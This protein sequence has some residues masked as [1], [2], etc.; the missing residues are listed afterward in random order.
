[1]AKTNK[2]NF[3]IISSDSTGQVK[4][5]IN[6]IRYIYSIGGHQVSRVLDLEKR[7]PGKA[8]D[9]LKKAAGKNVKKLEDVKE[10]KIV[11]RILTFWEENNKW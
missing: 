8:F 9:F 5:E 11:N 3:K 1:M 10:E 2:L 7:T 4:V 6:G